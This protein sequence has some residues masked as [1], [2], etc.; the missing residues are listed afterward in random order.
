MVYFSGLKYPLIDISAMVK[1]TGLQYRKGYIPSW[2]H[3]FPHKWWQSS[4][5]SA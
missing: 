3:L 5:W 4:S 1:L 2:W